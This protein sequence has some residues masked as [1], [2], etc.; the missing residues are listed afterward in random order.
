MEN[1]VEVQGWSC[2]CNR[3]YLGQAGEV[4]VGLKGGFESFKGFSFPLFD[5]DEAQILWDFV[6]CCQQRVHVDSVG[7]YLEAELP[8]P[9]VM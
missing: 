6:A 5:L 1:S 3:G 2:E 7:L 8:L 4:F 9:R